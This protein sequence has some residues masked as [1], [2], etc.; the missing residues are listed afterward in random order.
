MPVASRSSSGGI[1]RIALPVM[2][3]L[4]MN[5]ST[6]A[7][8]LI[9]LLAFFPRPQVALHRAGPRGCAS[10]AARACAR[11]STSAGSRASCR[12][13]A[14]GDSPPRPSPTG[15]RSRARAAPSPRGR[16]FR[17]RCRRRGGACRRRGRSR[18][19]R[20]AELDREAEP[21]QVAVRRHARVAPPVAG[22]EL[23]RRGSRRSRGSRR[24]GRR[25]SARRRRG[26]RARGSARAAPPDAA[27]SIGSTRRPPRR[28]GT[29]ISSNRLRST[30]S[31]WRL[32]S[33][34]RTPPA[35]NAST[36]RTPPAANLRRSSRA[37]EWTEVRGCIGRFVGG[38]GEGWRPGACLY[39][40]PGAPMSRT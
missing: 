17:W 20:G 12:S 3:S 22:D 32:W 29:A 6:S 23:L 18:R 33:C 5:C 36:S 9:R 7:T 40:R 19:R 13:S 28:A 37:V 15:A 1:S 26:R 4:R 34:A 39:H 14:R 21:A 38:S 10:G 27:R 30:T 2:S 35:T 11:P 25:R 8:T 31:V 16:A 24:R